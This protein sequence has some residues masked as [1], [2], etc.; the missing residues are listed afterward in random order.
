MKEKQ[1][2]MILKVFSA[3]DI[4]DMSS[5]EL[6]SK[7]NQLEEANQI[8]IHWKNKGLSRK[9]LDKYGIPYTED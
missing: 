9:Y 4:H 2:M 1:T 6:A 5:A 7:L 8:L 3:E